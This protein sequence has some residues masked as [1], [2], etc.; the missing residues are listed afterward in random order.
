MF[1]L[2]RRSLGKQVDKQS[3]ATREE[4]KPLRDQLNQAYYSPEPIPQ[5]NREYYVARSHRH[6]LRRSK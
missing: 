1:V 5:N 2:R 6:R 4:V 3:W